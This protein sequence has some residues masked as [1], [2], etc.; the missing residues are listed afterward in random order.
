[1]HLGDMAKLSELRGLKLA[2]SAMRLGAHSRVLR[3]RTQ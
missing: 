2:D 1:M 3:G